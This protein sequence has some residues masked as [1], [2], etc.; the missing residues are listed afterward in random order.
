VNFLE[1][2]FRQSPVKLSNLLCYSRVVTIHTRTI[3]VYQVDQ[4][5]VYQKLTLFG[6]E[7][8]MGVD[9]LHLYVDCVQLKPVVW[10]AVLLFNESY[11]TI[12]N[13]VPSV[14]YLEKNYRYFYWN[15][16][17]L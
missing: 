14:T 6:Y 9:L 2:W 7:G 15:Y 5:S 13:L 12:E 8:L 11:E 10:E 16:R 17:Y 1:N 3:L 4:Y